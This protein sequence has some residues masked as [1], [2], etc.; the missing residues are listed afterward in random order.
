[1]VENMATP[2]RSLMSLPMKLNS[3][4]L[5]RMALRID[6]ICFAIEDIAYMVSL[7]ISSRH[8]QLAV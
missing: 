7:L 4:F 5:E 6:W 3:Y 8:S 1:M 2:G